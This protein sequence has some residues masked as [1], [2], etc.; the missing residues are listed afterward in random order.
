MNDYYTKLSEMTIF[1][2]IK[3]EELQPMLECLGA[4]ERT[5]VKGSFISIEE[6]AVQYVGLVMDGMI[7]MLKEDLWGNKT[8]FTMIN[9]EELFGEAFACGRES[10]ATVSFFAATDVCVLFLP[11]S[12]VM[13]SCSK[14][15]SF[16]HRLIENMVVHIADKNYQ[17]MEKLS[18]LSKKN[19]R[20]KI[21]TYLQLQMQRNN[22]NYFLCPLGRVEL[23]CLLSMYR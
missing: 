14:V 21:S 15:C 6:D 10:L 2:Q 4:Y 23:A 13:H 12:R 19:L 1:A 18:I 9:K 17:L 8:I 3:I 11:F 7:H 22:S 20:E 16:H 5:F